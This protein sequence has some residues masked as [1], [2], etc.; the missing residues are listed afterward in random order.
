MKLH[1]EIDSVKDQIK[2]T[3]VRL[4]PFSWTKMA[5]QKAMSHVTHPKRKWKR[6]LI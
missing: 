2:S 1:K 6:I 5:T 3:A 4:R